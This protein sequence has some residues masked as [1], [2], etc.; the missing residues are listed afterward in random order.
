M[1][2]KKAKKYLD[3][4]IEIE[5]IQDSIMYRT[6]KRSA[7]IAE[8]EMRERAIEAHRKYCHCYIGNG[9]CRMSDFHTSCKNI[10]S[11]N[12]KNEFI[13]RIDKTE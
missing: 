9:N 7:E 5:D 11:C 13:E 12:Y 1:K 6:A 10:I 3:E 4:I 2:S 8:E